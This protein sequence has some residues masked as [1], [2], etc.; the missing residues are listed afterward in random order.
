MNSLTGMIASNKQHY[1]FQAYLR[2]FSSDVKKKF[3]WACIKDNVIKELAIK[4]VAFSDK[5]YE[6]KLLNNSEIALF[7]FVACVLNSGNAESQT[8]V[9]EFI[10]AYN[11]PSNLVRF[12]NKVCDAICKNTDAN[13]IK[14]IKKIIDNFKHNNKVSLINMNER[15]YSTIESEL[16]AYID[17]IINL[18]FDEIKEHRRRIVRCML[19][20]YYRT[21]IMRDSIKEVFKKILDNNRNCMEIGVEPSVVNVDNLLTPYLLFMSM[22]GN[23]DFDIAVIKNE[24]NIDFITCDQPMINLCADYKT[25]VAPEKF[26]FYYPVSPKFAILVNDRVD[27]ILE[28]VTSIDKVNTL[29]NKIVDAHGD[30]LFAS[31][32]HQLKEIIGTE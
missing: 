18:K 1:V 17:D 23:D 27:S 7:K 31:S 10:R 14:S 5:M 6:V 3:I 11:E 26:I 13:N 20:Q 28:C 32:E 9:D 8:C 24:T 25:N 12:V 21:K 15:Y 29:N 4:N 19:F 2:R 30:F 22:T 16:N